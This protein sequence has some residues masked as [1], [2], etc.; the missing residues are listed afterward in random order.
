MSFKMVKK[1][2]FSILQSLLLTLIK[3]LNILAPFSL[4]ANLCVIV[5][6][7]FIFYFCFNY[8]SGTL[9]IHIFILKYISE[10]TPQFLETHYTIYDIAHT[11]NP[12]PFPHLS[13]YSSLATFPTAFGSAVF[14]FEGIAVVLPL[15]VLKT[16][17]FRLRFIF[18]CFYRF[19][20][21]LNPKKMH[22]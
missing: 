4:V 21:P 17:R 10:K 2:H 22:F 12:S 15:R 13:L 7:L 6:V 19:P 14:A 11:V 20:D 1:A 8:L 3:S 18:N 9:A 16:M 5:S